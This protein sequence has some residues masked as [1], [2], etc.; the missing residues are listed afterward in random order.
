MKNKKIMVA[1]SGGVDSSAA[2]FLLQ[3]KGFEVI[4]VY[5]RLF[6]N[7][8][9][10]ED[11]ARRVCQKLGIKFY[12]VNLAEKFKQEVIE[13]FVDSYRDGITPNPCVKCNK[14]IK[15]GEMFR[16]MNELECDYLATGHYI[17]LEK[18]FSFGKF[19]FINKL[20][21][22]H[23]A[24]KDQSYFLYNLTQEQLGNIIFPL[25]AFEKTEIKKIASAEEL[26]TLSGESQDVCFLNIDGKI[27]EHNEYLREYIKQ[28][29]GPIKTLAGEIIGEHQG[30]SFYTLGQ[31]RGV[32]IGG[33]GPYY[34]VKMD[35]ENNTLYVS[36][37]HDDPALYVSELMMQEANWIAGA[38][39]KFTFACEAVIRYRH[40]EVKCVVE[41]IKTNKFLVKFSEPQR[42]VMP[43]QSVVLYCGDELIGGGVIGA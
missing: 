7:Q 22:G 29:P 25:G 31:R 1:M 11:A 37:D 15:F 8:G 18:K 19:K 21:R 24:S 36:S 4:G 33:T 39:P 12:P 3:K 38:E 16:I 5:M 14:L 40:K 26:P 23:D 28:A 32:E 27:A 41:K 34:V 17:K 35:Q 9:N 20:F 42:A 6:D 2:A 13:Y 43:G 10:S 30:L